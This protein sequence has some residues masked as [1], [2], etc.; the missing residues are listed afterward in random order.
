[1]GFGLIPGNARGR[2]V[3]DSLAALNQN[4]SVPVW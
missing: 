2:T 3:E 1:M 4:I